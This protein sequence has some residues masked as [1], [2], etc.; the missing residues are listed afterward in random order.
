[1]TNKYMKPGVF[2]KRAVNSQWITP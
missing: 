1:M 2:S